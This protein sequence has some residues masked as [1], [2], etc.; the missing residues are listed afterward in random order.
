[1]KTDWIIATDSIMSAPPQF[2]DHFDPRSLAR[3]STRWFGSAWELASMGSYGAGLAPYETVMSISPTNFTKSEIIE[4]SDE[5][6]VT[7]RGKHRKQMCREIIFRREIERMTI[8]RPAH[9]IMIARIA[10]ESIFSWLNQAK[11]CMRQRTR[12]ISE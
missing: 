7:S 10:E 9:S 5:R 12:S 4:P 6:A 2:L 1:M 11:P 3:T 8:L